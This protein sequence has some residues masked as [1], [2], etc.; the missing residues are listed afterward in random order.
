MLFCRGMDEHQ[1][2]MNKRSIFIGLAIIF[3][4]VALSVFL[5]ARSPNPSVTTELGL[6]PIKMKII[7]WEE[8][9]SLTSE[10]GC[11][12]AILPKKESIK[13][14]NWL[15][16]HKA[17][18]ETNPGQTL[19]QNSLKHATENSQWTPNYT[20]NSFS[21]HIVLKPFYHWNCDFMINRLNNQE[22][23]LYFFA[24]DYFN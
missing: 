8:S 5:W 14:Q 3:G 24:I 18:L 16:N 13:L 19:T 11:L 17:S 22:D 7:V 21:G 12:K 4:A 20:K 15:R 9:S 1:I 6:P 2:I 23:V 10:R